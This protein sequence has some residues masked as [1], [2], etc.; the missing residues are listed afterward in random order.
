[1]EAFLRDTSIN[2]KVP[3]SEKSLSY[4][5]VKETGVGVSVLGTS[6]AVAIGAYNFA[7]DQM[8]RVMH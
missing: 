2:I 4:D 3:F 8:N 1:M 6:E 5:P 7:L